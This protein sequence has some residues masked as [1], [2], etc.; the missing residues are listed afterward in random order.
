MQTFLFAC[1]HNA[2]RSQMSAAFF[3]R[4]A[5]PK[6]ARSVSAGTQPGTQVH[7]VVADVMREIGIDLAGVKPQQL[8]PQF[9]E[10]ADRFITM[11]AETNAP[12][13]RVC[14]A[15]TWPPSSPHGQEHRGGSRDTRRDPLPG[16]RT[17]PT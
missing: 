8:T 2:G 11:G 7:P 6:R 12:S 15:M 4:L 14:R 17:A 1:I 10:R 3:Y 13:F 9:A 16:C 5:D